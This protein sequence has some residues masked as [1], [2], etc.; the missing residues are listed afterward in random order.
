MRPQQIASTGLKCIAPSHQ[1]PFEAKANLSRYMAGRLLQG[2]F[3][4]LG[5]LTIVFFLIRVSGDPANYF[6]SLDP[7]KTQAEVESE[8]RDI[9]RAMGLDRPVIVQYSLFLVRSLRGEF[10]YSSRY[11]IPSTRVVFERLPNSLKLGAAAAVIGVGVGLPLGVFAALKRGSIIDSLATTTAVLGLTV[12]GFWLGIMLI[13]VFAV[14]LH[15]LPAAGSGSWKH[16]ILPAV[17][18][19][20]G[21]MA[22]VA[23]MGRSGMLEVLN[24]DYIRTARSKGLSNGTV[25]FR[26]ALQNASISLITVVGSSVPHLIGTIVI[27]EV[28]FAW[29]GLGS[30]MAQSVFSRDYPVILL[31]VVL[32]SV[33]TVVVFILVDV[34]YAVVD[35]RIRYR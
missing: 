30:L 22:V 31:G 21:L 11:N 32:M 5:V 16:L 19:S 9:R 26:H 10:G 14:K 20:A 17:T 4:V 34:L 18:Q 6:V 24:Q 2:V 33:I 23:R 1:T 3:V 25:I 15:L 28:V 27:V 29:P 13:I 7:G 35:P 8:I 12:P